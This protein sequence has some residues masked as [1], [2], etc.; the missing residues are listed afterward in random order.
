MSFDTFRQDLRYGLRS[1]FAKPGFLIAAVATLA[2]G[3]GA[4]TAIFS[5]I[6]GLLLKPLPY[7]DGER[8]VQVHNAYPKMGLDDA[9]T[10]IPD[11]LDRKEQAPALED[12]AIY[13]GESFNLAADG[14]PQRLVGLRAS[15]S[16]WSTLRAKAALGRVFNESEGELG[17]E[18]VV[19]LSDASWK[20]QFAS[21]PSIVGRDVRMNGDSYKVI[22]VMPPDFAFPNRNVQVW[23]PFAF[24]P[25]QKSDNERGSEFSSSVGRLA[26]GATIAQLQEQMDAIIRRNAERALA[27][28]DPSLADGAAFYLGGNFVGRAKSLRDQWVGE[29]KP[30]LWLLQ[31]VV[32]FVLLIACANVANL[33]LT[34]VTARQKELSV[35]TALGAGRSRI[36]RQLMVEALVLSTIGAVL[37]ITLA[38]FSLDLLNWLGLSKSQLSAQVGI[39]A[40][41]LL[42]TLA[43]AAITG[44]AF[45]L[46][47]AMMQLGGK[48]YEILKEGGRGNTMGRG[49]KATRNTLVVVQMALAVTLLVGAGLLIKSFSRV[50]DQDPGFQK[51][52]LLS[53]RI[54]LPAG[55]YPD[56]ATQS[57]FYERAVAELSAVP[58][59]TGAAYISNLPFGGSVAT[60][61]Y[62]IEGRPEVPGEASPHGYFRA[63]DEHFFSTMG[64][65]L[66]QGR[67]FLPT[68]TATSEKVIVIDD[69][70]AKKHFKD[71]N[72]IGKRLVRG[73]DEEPTYWTIIG[74][75][76]TTKV[77]GL[78]DDVKKEAYYFTHRQLPLNNGFFV[79]KTGL[80]TGGLVQPVRDAILRVDPEQPVYDIKSID[81]RIALSLEG[82]RAPMVLLAIFAGVALVLSAIGIYG[83]L[84][85]SVEQRTSE[86]GVR[87]AIG[88]QRG[89]ITKLV[90]GQGGKI[91]GIGLA[92]GLV[93]SFALTAFMQSQ[94]FGVKSGDPVT[95][96]AVIAVLGAVALLACWLPARR[97]AKTSPMVALRYE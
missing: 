81:E 90:M 52:G 23:V 20:A 84:A 97:A 73:S 10:S 16:L 31:A 9:G 40:S 54:D 91:A 42:F 37:G 76:G 93:G 3:I 12:L 25:E 11:F 69:V 87:M 88:A 28:G 80:P 14:T 58:G 6:N 94:L 38:Y 29:L 68:D 48:P 27:S 26:P 49:A 92:I 62:N 57:R 85:F 96:V 45:G 61:S 72:P 33:M 7:D 78:T 36:A 64:I 18:K 51:D 56:E 47:P 32:G 53:V 74:V 50:L 65:P 44:V 35:R 70:L 75:V 24:T 21:D 71:E 43:V 22:G 82:R 46:F 63:A 83:V 5:V 41:V 95:L 19:V 77:S 60:S 34:R 55:K 8:L 89:D 86:L 59:V 67:T 66:L 39:D 30:V 15:P 79:V 13:T 17:N 1:L 4:N 2:L